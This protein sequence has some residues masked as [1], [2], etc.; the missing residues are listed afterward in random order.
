MIF[1][2][3]NI[4]ICDSTFP[5]SFT[6]V[7]VLDG[8]K[9]SGDR[10]VLGLDVAGLRE[11]RVFSQVLLMLNIQAEAYLTHVYFIMSLLLSWLPH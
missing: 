11:I 9:M 5:F 4:Y 6:I 8:E 10:W 1:L 7:K 3:V 2:Q